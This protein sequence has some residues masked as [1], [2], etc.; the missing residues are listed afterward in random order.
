MEE[1]V[2]Y[3][4]II[5]RLNGVIEVVEEG[6]SIR[7]LSHTKPGCRIVLLL[8]AL[9]P[10]LAPYQLIFQPD[11]EDFFNVFFLFAA[12]ISLGALAVSAFFVWAAI[13]GLNTV[14]R[15]D[16]EAGTFTY[17]IDAPILQLRTEEFGLEAID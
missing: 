7:L 12:V 8:L 16:K 1:S 5:P 4:E 11:W 13:A 2:S 17:S 3:V 9:F 10:L 14:L 6:N 15:F